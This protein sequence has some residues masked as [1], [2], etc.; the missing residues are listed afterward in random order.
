[1]CT[2]VRV[3]ISKLTCCTK[4]LLYV[5]TFPSD[6]R[7]RSHHGQELT[8]IQRDP[9]LATAIC[10]TIRRLLAERTTAEHARTT[11]APRAQ[12]SHLRPIVR[13]SSAAS[14][15]LRV[16]AA[17]AAMDEGI[18]GSGPERELRDFDG[19]DK[20]HT[21]SSAGDDNPGQKGLWDPP[22]RRAAAYFPPSKPVNASRLVP[23]SSLSAASAG[24]RRPGRGSMEDAQLG[25]PRSPLQAAPP[26]SPLQAAP[27]ATTGL[28]PRLNS[29]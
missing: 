10:V 27:P 1:M 9:A 3:K 6:C 21:P 28:L 18:G 24:G 4:L 11:A 22:R 25:T 20:S 13:R 19:S 29:T 23:T 15:S 16:A 2:Y 14:T 7:D 17:A 26:R 5:L 12:A 8:R